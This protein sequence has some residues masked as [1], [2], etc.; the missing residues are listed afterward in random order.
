MKN[1]PKKDK[2]PY[3]TMKILILFVVI[4]N[5]AAF[6][7]DEQD[8]NFEIEESV[9]FGSGDSYYEPIYT[10]DELL[11]LDVQPDVSN[12]VD[13][14]ICKS[15]KCFSDYRTPSVRAPHRLERPFENFQSSRGVGVPE[16]F[17][18]IFLYVSRDL[19]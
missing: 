13:L 15:S 6:A 10:A 3:I 14:D 18:C 11:N 8:F 19:P 5:F 7:Q 16:F 4:F 1:T 9:D 12:D 2:K 17:Y